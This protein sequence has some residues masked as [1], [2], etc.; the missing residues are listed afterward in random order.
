[1]PFLELAAAVSGYFR[2]TPDG[3][4]LF[5]PRGAFG[6]GYVVRSPADEQRLR[7]QIKRW[8]IAIM[9]LIA[10]AIVL[11]G[12]L[13]AVVVAALCLAFYYVWFGHY[14]TRGLQPTGEPMRLR[15]AMIAQAMQIS[16]SSL[17]FMVLLSLVMT[18]IGIFLLVN[19]PSEWRTATGCLVL[20][21][22]LGI[23]FAWMLLLRRAGSA[24]HSGG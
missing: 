6:R 5:F 24:A 10:G 1:M 19:D 9:V 12:F 11:G 17:W 22:P 14:L 4:V 15:E 21:V 23:L 13:A 3:R 16:R 20:F 2:K 7:R 8:I 18:A